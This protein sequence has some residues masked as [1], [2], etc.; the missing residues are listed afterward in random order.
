VLR[1]IPDERFTNIL[2]Q[3]EEI[4]M[5]AITAGQLANLQKELMWAE[6][7]DIRSVRS[8]LFH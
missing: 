4:K 1:V 3:M 7:H 6:V 5:R 8:P 2:L